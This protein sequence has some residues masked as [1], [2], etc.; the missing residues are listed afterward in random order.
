MNENIENLLFAVVIGY[1][2]LS[3]SEGNIVMAIILASFI[4]FE[5]GICKG[6]Y[7]E[8]KKSK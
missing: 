2:S 6:M 5:L 3:I 7:D 8:Y 1:A 4:G